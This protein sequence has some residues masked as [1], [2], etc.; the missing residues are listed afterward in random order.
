MNQALTLVKVWYAVAVAALENSI[1]TVIEFIKNRK[2]IQFH[3]V[4][5]IIRAYEN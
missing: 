2:L 1:S 3:A 4:Q 5:T